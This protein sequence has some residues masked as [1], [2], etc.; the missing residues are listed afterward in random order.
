MKFPKQE[1]PVVISKEKPQYMFCPLLKL[2][3]QLFR[4]Q[5]WTFFKAKIWPFLEV[6]FPSLLAIYIDSGDTFMHFEL[7]C[8]YLEH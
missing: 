7:I 1:P 4:S 2:P 6:F 5:K 3:K 8:Q